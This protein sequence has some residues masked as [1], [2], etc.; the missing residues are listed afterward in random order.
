MKRI[1][2]LEKKIKDLVMKCTVKESRPGREIGSVYYFDRVD[3]TM[4]VAFSLNESELRN[5]TVVLAEEQSRGRGRNNRKW[6]GSGDDIMFS[7]VLTVFDVKLPYSMIASY[8]VYEV[9]K[10]YTDNL[11]LKWINDLYIEAK[12]V[13]GILTEEKLNRTVI[14]VGVNV[15]RKEFP[16]SILNIATSLFIETGRKFDRIKLTAELLSSIIYYVRLAGEEGPESVL[17]KW[18]KASKMKGVDVRVETASGTYYGTAMGINY[19]T[20]ALKIK[21][22]NELVEIYEGSLF[23]Y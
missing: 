18:E 19:S 14:G 11:L 7:L 22:G 1:P 6:F 15:N 2:D 16:E 20:G 9:L 12:K 23:F 3:S 13:A 4:D 5:N 10:N 8:A 21:D 17:K